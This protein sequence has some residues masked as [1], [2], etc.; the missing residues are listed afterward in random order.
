MNT[1]IIDLLG[2]IAPGVVA[3]L[4]ASWVT[5]RLAL[6]RFKEEAIWQR[7][8]DAYTRILDALHV[9]RLRSERL[10]REATEGVQFSDDYKEEMRKKYSVATA[11]LHRVIDTG[12]LILPQAVTSHLAEVMTPRYTDWKEM[13]PYEFWETE[14]HQMKKALEALIKTGRADLK[15]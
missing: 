4:V 1:E 14:E 10:A 6:G 5:V 15:R 13:S 8:L 2:K 9:C 7:K 3:A 12:L 11:E